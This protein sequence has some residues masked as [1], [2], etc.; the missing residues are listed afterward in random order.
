MWQWNEFGTKGWEH[1]LMGI[2]ENLEKMLA[3]GRDDAML[4][5]GLGSACF[6]EDR[7]EEASVHLEACL[8]HDGTYSA[9]YK[10]L[11]RAYLKQGEPGK[12]I[13]TFE[14][15]IPIADEQGD[16]QSGKEMQVF[17]SKAQKEMND[18]KA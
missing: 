5:F 12:A 11:G 15:G 13:A 10:L 2:V 9:A 17:L 1:N 16:K 18:D 6:N 14:T 7:Y 8:A 3:S 4:R